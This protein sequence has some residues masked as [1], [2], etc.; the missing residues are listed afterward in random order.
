[1]EIP[2]TNEAGS[3]SGTGPVASA[4]HLIDSNRYM[5]LGTVDPDGRPRVSA[6]PLPADPLHGPHVEVGVVGYDVRV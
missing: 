1:M 2:T 4:K 5:V 3:S 6:T